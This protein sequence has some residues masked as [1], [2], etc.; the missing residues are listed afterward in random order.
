M[1]DAG[2]RLSLICA[3]MAGVAYCKNL[4]IKDDSC[5]WSAGGNTAVEL[6]GWFVKEEQRL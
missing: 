1:V 4:A 2:D 6:L 5:A 3:I